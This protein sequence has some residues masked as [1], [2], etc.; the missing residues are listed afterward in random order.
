[1]FVEASALKDSTAPGPSS[2]VPAVTT[3]SAA[4]V[5]STAPLP[6]SSVPGTVTLPTVNVVLDM[7]IVPK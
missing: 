4:N 2:S 5:V 6:S 3:S 1:M 7:P